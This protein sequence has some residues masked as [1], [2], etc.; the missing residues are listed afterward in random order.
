MSWSGRRFPEGNSDGKKVPFEPQQSGKG[1]RSLLDDNWVQVRF[2]LVVD[3]R[4]GRGL[5]ESCPRP[6][7]KGSTRVSSGEPGPV[8]T[9]E[10][11]STS[12]ARKGDTGPR[13]REEDVV[14]GP[15]RNSVIPT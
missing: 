6:G 4:V 3:P 14:T 8:V 10:T 7:P 5:V 12:G 11:T 13:C 2:N 9:E 1:G 15:P